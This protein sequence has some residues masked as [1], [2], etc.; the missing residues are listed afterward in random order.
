MVDIK[1]NEM[2]L[3]WIKASIFPSP[4]FF[5]TIFYFLP[6]SRFKRSWDILLKKN[7]N[8]KDIFNF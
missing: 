5:H 3:V 7:K 1:S 8:Q 6:D 4:S 2:N